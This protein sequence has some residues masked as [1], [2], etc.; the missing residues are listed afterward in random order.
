MGDGGFVVQTSVDSLPPTH[1]SEIDPIQH[2]LELIEVKSVNNTR[3]DTPPVRWIPADRGDVGYP[4]LSR[5]DPD[6]KDSTQSLQKKSVQF[7]VSQGEGTHAKE[8]GEA[9]PFEIAGLWIRKLGP[10]FLE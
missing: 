7:V 8:C 5:V 9:V 6:L 4:I 10:D 1:F 3:R 2:V